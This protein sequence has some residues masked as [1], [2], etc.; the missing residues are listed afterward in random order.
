MPANVSTLIAAGK[1]AARGFKANTLGKVSGGDTIM[2]NNM[3]RTLQ[4][5]LLPAENDSV[6]SEATEWLSK[7]EEGSSVW[8]VFLLGNIRMIQQ[9]VDTWHQTM[10]RAAGSALSNEELQQD[11]N[12][13]TYKGTQ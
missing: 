8:N 13:T 7:A 6:R 12:G 4:L 2:L 5:Q 11:E 3:V 9:A 10:E 1:L